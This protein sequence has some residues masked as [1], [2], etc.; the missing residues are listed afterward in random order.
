MNWPTIAKDLRD[1]AAER[2]DKLSDD[3]AAVALEEFAGVIEGA[4]EREETA[5]R[6]HDLS[7]HES[8]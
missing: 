2:R 6:A 5:Q 4:L 1:R 8:R 7:K 3:L